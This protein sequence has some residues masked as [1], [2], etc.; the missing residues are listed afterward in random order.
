MLTTVAVLASLTFIGW[1]IYR[2]VRQ[3]PFKA[4]TISRALAYVAGIYTF[5]FFLS[6]DIPQLFKIVV[7]ILLGMVLIV[8]AAYLQRHRQTEKS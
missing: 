1:L 2:A 8:L 7:S 6:M 4:H 5:A 3:K